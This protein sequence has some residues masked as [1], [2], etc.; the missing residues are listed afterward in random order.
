MDLLPDRW[1]TE[2][3]ATYFGLDVFG[4]WTITKRRT[5][6]AKLTARGRQGFSYV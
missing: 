4:P 6:E 1:S 3:P 5:G 2:P